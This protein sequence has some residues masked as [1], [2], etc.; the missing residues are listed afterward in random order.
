MTE[1]STLR[2][3]PVFRGHV[4]AHSI[5]S[6]TTS[7]RGATFRP[8]GDKSSIHHVASSDFDALRAIHF[9]R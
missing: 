6:F 5:H 2:T 4:Y 1:I 8:V 3:D 7:L 9:R